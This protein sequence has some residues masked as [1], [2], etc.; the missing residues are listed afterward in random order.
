MKLKKLMAA[1]L[2]AAMILSGGA[3]TAMAADTPSQT[4]AAQVTPA[5]PAETTAPQ[6]VG[7]NAVIE[8]VNLNDEGTSHVLV[9]TEGENGQQIQLNV[10]KS[11]VVLDTKTGLPAAQNQLKKGDKVFVYHNTAMTR[12]LPPQAYAQA[13]LVNLDETHAPAHLL[14]AEQVTKNEDGSVTLL[15]D[16]G[17]VLVKVTKDTPISP[18]YT[19]NIVR[20]TDIT[21]GSRIFAWYDIVALSMPGQATATKVVVLPAEE[22]EQS[23]DAKTASLPANGTELTI[24]SEG[25]IA[26]GK[27]KVENG[28]VMVPIRLVGEKLGFTVGWDGATETVT[29]ANGTAKTAV[30]LG[31]DSYYKAADNGTIGM[32]KPSP[33]GAAAYE[34]NGVSWAPAELF[35]L[36]MGEGTVTVKGDTIRL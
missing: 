30:K 23:G 26:I 25:D 33:L 4:P 12:S 36:L 2:S 27:G 13:I 31:L 21:E 16:N 22:K 9:K 34:V 19:K 5:A 18:L 32:S 15:A 7:A 8:E 10:D 24:I 6:Y 1:L 28:V 17:S 29:L 35:N 3:V 14:T 20:N 11:T